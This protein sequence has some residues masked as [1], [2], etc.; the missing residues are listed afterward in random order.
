M[1]TWLILLLIAIAIVAIYFL[2]VRKKPAPKKNNGNGILG[3]ASNVLGA[4]APV[5][6]A[7]GK[8]VVPLVRPAG[9]A[10]RAIDNGAI[11]V[12]NHIPIVGGVL[13]APLEGAKKVGSKISGW[14]GF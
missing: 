1:D 6:G 11:A 9:Q 13:S 8:A 10:L 4:V 2:F 7:I 5:Y 12:L 14:L 3:A